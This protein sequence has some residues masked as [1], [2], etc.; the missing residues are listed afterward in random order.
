MTADVARQAG[1]A[2]DAYRQLGDRWA[3]RSAP[4]FGTTPTEREGDGWIRV[5]DFAAD[6]ERLRSVVA[7]FGPQ[8]TVHDKPKAAA[9]L[10]SKRLGGL[11][12]FPATVGFMS[13]RRVI[14]LVPEHTW[15]RFTDGIPDRAAISEPYA[16][17]SATDRLAGAVDCEVVDEAA[18]LERLAATAYEATMGTIISALHTVFRTG[19]RHLWGNLSLA[20]INSAL[21]CPD[22]P[23]PWGD[24]RRLV[25]AL[26]TVEP[27]VDLVPCER[28]D[29]P[30]TLALRTTCCLA[31]ER[32][33]HG[34]CASCSLLDRDERI[35]DLSVSIGDLWR[36]SRQR[37]REEKAP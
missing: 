27:T 12:A 9:A 14:R 13:R 2:I 34:Y 17:V 10:L 28:D 4:L 18:Q 29:G 22:G 16:W 35:D 33:D 23:D 24:G 37:A 8:I 3:A 21:Y 31:Y 15:V 11:L 26:P 32:E 30:F 20:A 25:A 19:R 7:A 1:S 5:A 36:G 6:P